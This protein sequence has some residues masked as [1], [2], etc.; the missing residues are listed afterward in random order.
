MTALPPRP[1]IAQLRRLA[2]D[3][4]R[5][6]RR[7]DPDAIAWISEVDAGVTLSAAQLRLA[8]HHG[9]GSW[10]AMHLEI[11]RRRA[12]DGHDPDALEAFVSRHPELATSE[13]V[14][15]SDHPLGA[16]P[17]AFVAM[18]RFDTATGR[19]RDVTGSGAAARVLLAAGA[20]LDGT[21]DDRET[22][23]IT[24]ASY[25]DAEVAAALIAAGADLEAV[26]T[27]DAGGVPG[28]TAV[29]HAAVFGM[30]DVLDLLVRA[31]ARVRS[32][33]EAAAA[34][35]L[36][37]WL[38]EAADTQALLR[39]LVMA[40]D[41]Q[42]IAVIDRLVAAGTPVDEE[43]HVFGRH[44]LRLAATNGRP[45]SVRSL[46]AHGADPT[47]RDRSGRTAL[48]HCRTGRRIAADPDGHDEVEAI[49]D[50]AG[51]DRGSLRSPS[52]GR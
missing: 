13:L 2:K 12:L 36:A 4:L 9:F 34:G 25:G 18:A 28:G 20:P 38:G 1:D 19:W 24:A 8:R 37:E 33:E 14:N 48:D 52:S 40:A 32:I 22:P 26:A 29:L 35:D 6:A 27:D 45:A 31:G 17:L 49:L 3:R 5:E 30:T 7:G 41:H 11:A 23:L 15:W 47:G 39:A 10:P 42:R 21:P 44:P 50:A 46:L 43:D 51:T 16:S